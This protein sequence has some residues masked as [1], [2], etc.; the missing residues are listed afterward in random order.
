MIR[1]KARKRF[2]AGGMG[3]NVHTGAGTQQIPE[4]LRLVYEEPPPGYRVPNYG[5]GWNLEYGLYKKCNYGISNRRKSGQ[6]EF[7]TIK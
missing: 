1:R 2:H 6:R 7:Q 4:R 3:T 5:S